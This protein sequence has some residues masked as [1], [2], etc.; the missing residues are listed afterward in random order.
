MSS[1]FEYIN[2]KI[3]HCN[4][5]IQGIIIYKPPSTSKR[6]FLEEFSD[7]LDTLNDNRNV[8]ICGDFN[9]HMEDKTDNY[10]NEFMELLES[11]N[12]ENIVH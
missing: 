6:M 4:K 10:V 12:L 8:L 5:N 9:L 11:H 3:T 2:T 1:S 7:F